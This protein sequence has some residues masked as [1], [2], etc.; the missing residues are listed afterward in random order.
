MFW[1]LSQPFCEKCHFNPKIALEGKVRF[2]K[3][4]ILTENS[5]FFSSISIGNPEAYG[6][7]VYIKIASASIWNQA[8]VVVFEPGPTNF[9]GVKFCGRIDEL[10]SCILY[11]IMLYYIILK[12]E[13]NYIIL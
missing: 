3:I 2:F 5:H 1:F 6:K 8:I 11:Y 10:A 7:I 12:L 13:L 4:M 9:T